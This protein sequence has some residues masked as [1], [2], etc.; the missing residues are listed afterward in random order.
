MGNISH[1]RSGHASWFR[2]IRCSFIAAA[3][4]ATLHVVEA[5]DAPATP[6]VTNVPNGRPRIGLVLGGGG[7]KGA[8]HIGVIKVLE[9]LRIP[10]DCIAGTSMG[11][12][13]GAA[14]AT[15]LSSQEIEKII[16]AINWKE[17]LASAPR[18]DIPV[19]RKS[20]DF[21]FTLGLELGW[22]NGKVTGPGGLVSTHQVEGLFRSIVAGARQGSDFNKLP[23]PFRAV[24]TDLESGACRESGN[25]S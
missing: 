20:L 15:G 25:E 1:P 23:I 21:I 24:A 18:Q 22:K 13:V 8:A 19:Q 12:I 14:Y 16:T 4:L 9:E 10:I 5:A 7:A 17:I 2:L 6:N 3:L 11:S